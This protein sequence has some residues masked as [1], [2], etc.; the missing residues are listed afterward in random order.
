MELTS[1]RITCKN[2]L[3]ILIEILV[4]LGEWRLRV[5][6]SGVEFRFGLVL[7]SKGCCRASSFN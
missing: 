6:A 7:P 1:F 5:A 3:E 4:G 2:S